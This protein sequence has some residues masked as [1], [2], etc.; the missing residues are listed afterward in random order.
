[1]SEHRSMVR[2][3]PGLSAWEQEQAAGPDRI[4]AR[5]Q[6]LEQGLGRFIKGKPDVVR[7]SL[8]A[9][10]ARGHILI[11]DVP[12]VGKTTLALALASHLGGSFARIQFTSDL[13]PTDILGVSLYNQLESRFE[14]RPGP[15]FNHIVLA[16]EL[17]RTTPKTQSCLLEAMNDGKV[18][19][20]GVTR[21]LEQPFLVIA[22]QN[23][24]EHHGTFPLPESQLDRFLLRFAIGYPDQEAERQIIRGISRPRP[25][26]EASLLVPEEV[27]RGQE[28]V[29]R[30]R[31]SED[32]EAYLLDI[33]HATRTTR[34]LELGVSPR[35]ARH[36]Y[37]AAQ[38]SAFLDGRDHVIPDDIKRLAVPVLAHRVVPAGMA[39]LPVPAQEVEALM[40][41]L[42]AAVPVPD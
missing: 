37:R 9:I 34:R 40:A 19:I 6:E 26:E 23:P 39:G 38:A 17:N 10:L 42:V 33:V 5:F 18:S 7:L 16:D 12:G 1:M 20:D 30:I 21:T 11:E 36:L 15:I 22:T 25:G 3:E 14:F 41:D 8:V 27:V 13:L 2:A 24:L 35:G 32:L 4:L 29:G 31:V 28:L